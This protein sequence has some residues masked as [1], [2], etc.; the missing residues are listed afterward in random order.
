VCVLHAAL[1]VALHPWQVLFRSFILRNGYETSYICLARRAAKHNNFWNRL[2]RRGSTTRRLL[3]Y[4]GLQLVFTVICCTVFLPTYFSFPLAVAYQV[5]LGEALGMYSQPRTSLVE[6]CV[7]QP[8]HR[9]RFCMHGKTLLS[10][11]Q[12]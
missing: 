11:R 6:P 2:V 4:G 9:L 3:L 7:A 5:G 10:D 8:A 1:P 12:A